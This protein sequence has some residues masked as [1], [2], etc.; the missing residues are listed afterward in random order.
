MTSKTAKY[1]IVVN[2][3]LSVTLLIFCV[4]LDDV[5]KHVQARLVLTLGQVDDSYIDLVQSLLK[6]LHTDVMVSTRVALCVSVCLLV[7]AA[8]CFVGLLPARKHPRTEKE[9][10][11]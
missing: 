11:Q 9:K 8:V 4:P 3:A 5:F 1:F 6:A 10:C 2:L 7:N